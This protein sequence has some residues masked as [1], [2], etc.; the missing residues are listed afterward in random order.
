MAA[1]ADAMAF[2]PPSKGLKK[3]VKGRLSFRKLMDDVS[4]AWL[5]ACQP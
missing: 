5:L 1:I 4:G 3:G 2:L